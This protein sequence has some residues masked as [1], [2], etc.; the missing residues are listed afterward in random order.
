MF[1]FFKTSQMKVY[2][3]TQ[4]VLI[5]AECFFNSYRHNAVRMGKL[6][7]VQ[8]RFAN[9]KKAFMTTLYLILF[10]LSFGSICAAEGL[11]QSD[12]NSPGR[13]AKRCMNGNNTTMSMIT[14]DL[15]EL[16]LWDAS[17]AQR[18]K[19]LMLSGKAMTRSF[20]KRR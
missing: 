19:N 9:N 2:W 1:Y 18:L 13:Y 16:D 4:K 8:L 14:C 20:L 6:S 12:L 3:P 5:W 17:L 11:T 15:E 10:T 7:I